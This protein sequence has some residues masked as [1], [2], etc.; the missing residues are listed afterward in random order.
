MFVYFYSKV[1]I[2]Y[3]EHSCENAYKKVLFCLDIIFIDDSKW[4]NPSE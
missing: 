4:S 2:K 3:T 1:H